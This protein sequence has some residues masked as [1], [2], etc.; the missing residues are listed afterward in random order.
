MKMAN[1]LTDLSDILFAQL[2]RIEDERLTGEK[3]NEEISRSK[4]AVDVAQ[5]II[6]DGA[7]ILNACKA[8]D[9]ASHALKLPAMLT[10]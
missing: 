6:A 7:L 9:C 3:L 5:A 2:N 8:S 1:K 4:A 10:D